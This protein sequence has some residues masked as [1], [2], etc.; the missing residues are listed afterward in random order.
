MRSIY[1]IHHYLSR[2]CVYTKSSGVITTAVVVQARINRLA[3]KAVTAVS[4]KARA[5]LPKT[6]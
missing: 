6:I 4:L 5:C 1:L 3:V 2:A